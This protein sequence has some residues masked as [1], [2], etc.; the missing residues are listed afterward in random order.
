[1]KSTNHEEFKQFIISQKEITEAHRIS[2]GG[3]YHLKVK[4]DGGY[5]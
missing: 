2:G 1:M 3:C 4:V 5:V